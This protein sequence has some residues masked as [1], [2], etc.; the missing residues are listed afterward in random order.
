MKRRTNNSL[1]KKT[2]LGQK[3]KT[4]AR[5]HRKATKTAKTAVVILGAA[6]T[7]GAARQMF[8]RRKSS[9]I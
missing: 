5:K 4:F 9:W 8:K 7:L 6:A 3:Y 1:N 2:T